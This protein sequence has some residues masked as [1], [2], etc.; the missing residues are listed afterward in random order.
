MAP[1]LLPL[2][3]TAALAWLDP[4]TVRPG[5]KGVCITEWTGGERR[6]IP[7]EILGMLDAS[8]PDRSAVLVRLADE[9]MAGSGVVAG[10]SGSPVYIDG[11]LLGAIAF[12]W[13]FAREPLAGVTPFSTMRGIVTGGV[14]P[15]APAPTLARL[16]ALAA[17]RLQ[18]LAVL[19]EL[20][21]RDGRGPQLVAVGGL[22]LAGGFPGELLG[23]MG[24]HAVPAGAGEA[25]QGVPEAGDMMAALLVWGD[26]T[27]AAGGT[28]TAREGDQVWAFGHP[29]F[30][31]GRVRMPAARARVLAV[32]DSY[33][34]PFKL[35]AVGTSFGTV[36]ADRPA[37]VLARVGEQAAGTPVT[38]TVRDATG[39]ATWHFRVAEMPILQPLLVTYL[40]SASL[41][42]RGAVTGEA[43]VRLMLTARLADGREVQVRQ[44]AR[45]FDALAR[46]SAFAG[47][48]V[49]LLANSSFPHP[50]VSAVEVSLDR[51]EQPRGATIVEVVPARISVGPG[52]ELPVTVRL[53]PYQSAREERRVVIRVP[54]SARPGPL[55]LVVADGAS[56]SEYRLRAE[57]VTPADFA[58]QLTQVGQLESST[59]LVVALEAREPG[60]ALPGASEPGVPPSWSFTLATGLG[61]RALSRIPTSVVAAERQPGSFPLEGSIR[62]SLTV[63]ERPEV[64]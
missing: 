18:P 24:L 30:A 62:V 12:G 29:L 53:Q 9:R 37:G 5:Q 51:D 15:D 21:P 35:F 33:Q 52:E 31:L 64:P 4:T 54:Q 58:D 6:E 13:A 49:G 14:A 43:S 55:D 47:G 41:S 34:S 28:V 22:P 32:Q 8:G 19:P 56:W 40:A 2:T 25:P 42:A 7:V 44:A 46:M 63:R 10:M 50:P 45:G 60:V 11:K 27:I 17:G 3:L 16:A 20:P 1:L 36:V 23:A 61:A 59:T 38:V 39:T 26:A 48:V 57:A